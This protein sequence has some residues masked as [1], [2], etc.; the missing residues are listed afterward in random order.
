MIGWKISKSEKTL[1]TICG[2]NYG[3]LFALN[4]LSVVNLF[5]MRRESLLQNDVGLPIVK[6][7]LGVAGQQSVK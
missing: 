1:P 3:Y 5:V 6:T 4:T 7:F 2:I